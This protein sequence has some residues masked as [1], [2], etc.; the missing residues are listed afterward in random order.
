MEAG[1]G[2][3][4]WG[5]SAERGAARPAAGGSSQSSEPPLSRT[6]LSLQQRGAGRE[7]ERDGKILYPS[8]PL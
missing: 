6:A 3:G 4:A 5:E 8:F 2:V 7:R 1:P